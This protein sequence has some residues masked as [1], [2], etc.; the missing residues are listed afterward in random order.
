MSP[1]GREAVIPK[2]V[3]R[4]L[5]GRVPVVHGNLLDRLLLAAA[6]QAFGS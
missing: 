3:A 4:C 2:R 5:Y 6:T 1:T